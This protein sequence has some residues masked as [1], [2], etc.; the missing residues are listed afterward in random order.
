MTSKALDLTTVGHALNELCDAYFGECHWT[1]FNEQQCEFLDWYAAYRDDIK[2]LDNLEALA[3]TDY[4]ELNAFLTSKGFDPMFR[5]FSSFGV[6]SISDMLVEWAIKGIV[7]TITRYE[8]TGS[9]DYLNLQTGTDHPA[10]QLTSA[11]AD[12]FD[13]AG[14]DSPLVRLHTTTGHSVWLMKA[15]EPTSGMALNREAVH[16]LNNTERRHSLGWSGV[17]VPML[18]MDVQPDLS[19]ML[20][21]TTITPTLGKYVLEQLITAKCF[22]RSAETPALSQSVAAHSLGPARGAGC[23]GGHRLGTQRSAAY[24]G[25]QLVRV[26]RDQRARHPRGSARGSGSARCGAE[27]GRPGRGPTVQHSSA[28]GPDTRRIGAD[29]RRLPRL[30]ERA[31][32]GHLGGRVL[33]RRGGA[34]TLGAP[35]RVSG[36]F[37]RICQ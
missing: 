1:G 7:T 5:P 16:L 36:Q 28:I 27:S 4:T 26:R 15:P 34:S 14:Y 21:T 9:V 6:A 10:F 30:V 13:A 11:S 32:G 20:G 3:S 12:I 31:S 23:A 35:G 37:E 8:Q 17:V 33:Y 22:G 29:R 25:S 19:W 18:D 2:K 24:C